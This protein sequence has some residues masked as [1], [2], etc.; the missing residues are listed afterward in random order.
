MYNRVR[1]IVIVIVCLWTTFINQDC[2]TQNLPSEPLSSPPVRVVVGLLRRSGGTGGTVLLCQRSATA[3]YALQWEFP[4]GK[5][6]AGETLE[7]ALQRELREELSIDAVIGECLRTD[8]SDYADGGQFEVS[9][10]WVTA[11]RGTLTNNVFHDIAFVR[12]ADFDQY[13]ILQGNAAVCK[14]LQTLIP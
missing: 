6:E 4:G 8:V 11:W 10:F 9:Y 3:R 12:P 13:A 14:Q 5:V 2:M 7:A 1:V